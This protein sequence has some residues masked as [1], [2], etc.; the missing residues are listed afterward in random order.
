[1]REPKRGAQLGGLIAK[2]LKRGIHALGPKEWVR[3][4][5]EAKR[6]WFNHETQSK[7]GAKGGT[8]K[9]QR[10]TLACQANGAKSRTRQDSAKQAELGR[11]GGKA[12]WADPV[13][14]E[15][16]R[17]N[18]GRFKKGQPSTNPKGNGKLL[19]KHSQL[20]HHIRWHVQRGTRG[21]S[22]PLC[23]PSR[24]TGVRAKPESIER[25]GPRGAITGA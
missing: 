17:F 19:S 15:A 6:G 2:G 22:C 4:N 16:Q 8:Q 18:K 21:E 20:G 12:A 11:R 1:M 7:L 10:K 14:R 25:I 9:S 13:F 5:R 23:N 3:I 24:K